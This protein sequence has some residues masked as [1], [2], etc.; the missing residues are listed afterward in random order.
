[1]KGACPSGLCKLSHKREPFAKCFSLFVLRTEAIC[2]CKGCS[3][4]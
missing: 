2:P 3:S 1:M 4:C